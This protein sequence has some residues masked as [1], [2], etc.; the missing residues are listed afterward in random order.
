MESVQSEAFNG[1][2]RQT[3]TGG[4]E[5]ERETGRLVSMD[6]ARIKLSTLSGSRNQDRPFMEGGN[7]RRRG[8]LKGL[9]VEQVMRVSLRGRQATQYQMTHGLY[10]STGGYLPSFLLLLLICL[11]WWQYNY[12]CLLC[13]H[14]TSSSRARVPLLPH[15]LSL[16]LV[17]QLGIHPAGEW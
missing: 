4:R 17:D 9:L 8:S 14:F 13:C 2:T 16:A 11:N 1:H 10:I 3:G 15:S 5:R 6:E 7:G 12:I